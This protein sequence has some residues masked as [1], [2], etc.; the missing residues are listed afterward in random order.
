[1]DGRTNRQTDGRTNRLTDW[2]IDR[3]TD[4]WK[5]R[6]NDRQTDWWI[7]GQINWQMGGQTD[8]QTDDGQTD[9]LMDA[10]IDWLIDWLKADIT[11]HCHILGFHSI[12]TLTVIDCY[13]KLH[14]LFRRKLLN[15]FL[16]P[17]DRISNSELISLQP[18]ITVFHQV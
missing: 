5:D 16:L 12:T 8:R 18:T 15:F 10:S 3:Q 1:M 2:L 17:L 6:Q 11:I 9:W 4:K 13:F 7:G 14:N